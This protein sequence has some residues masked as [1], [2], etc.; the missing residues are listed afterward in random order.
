MAEELV[1]MYDAGLLN[2][3]ELLL[4]DNANRKWNPHGMLPYRNYDRF[5]LED[6]DGS[7]FLLEFRFKKEEIYNLAVALRLPEVF[8]CANGVVADSVTAMHL[9]QTL[10]VPLSVCRLNT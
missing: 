10:I 6:M 3:E 4:F 1:L 9:S 8:R 5:V 2:D 7:Q